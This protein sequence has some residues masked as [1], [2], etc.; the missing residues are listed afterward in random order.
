MSWFAAWFIEHQF[1]L[2]TLGM[3]SCLPIISKSSLYNTLSARVID[4]L[5]VWILELITPCLMWLLSSSIMNLRIQ[6]SSHTHI[7]SKDGS[8]NSDR[9]HISFDYGIR[10]YRWN[11]KISQ[12]KPVC[13]LPSTMLLTSF[14]INYC[15]N[16]QE[17]R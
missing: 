1:S 5:G 9:Q 16:F 11:C 12:Y 6:E 2:S 15:R 3:K 10:I 13:W 14:A 8:W 17:F 4:I 7:G